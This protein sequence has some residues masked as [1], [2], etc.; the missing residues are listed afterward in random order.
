MG[1]PSNDEV[2][3][4]DMASM[5]SG[6]HVVL[7]LFNQAGQGLECPGQR[8][9]SNEVGSRVGGLQSVVRVGA[10]VM[11]SCWNDLLA[12]VSSSLAMLSTLAPRS[13]ANR[14][15]ICTNGYCY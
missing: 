9:A 6:S 10:L 12:P 1:R 8:L 7:E 14:R 5:V 15:Q 3:E 4:Q 11:L 2:R 13:S